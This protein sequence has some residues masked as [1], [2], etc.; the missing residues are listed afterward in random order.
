M[1]AINSTCFR[2]TPFHFVEGTEPSE[3]KRIKKENKRRRK[4][5]HKRDTPSSAAPVGLSCLLAVEFDDLASTLE[6]SRAGRAPSSHKTR[7]V[8]VVAW[9][10]SS[11]SIHFFSF[12]FFVS[13]IDGTSPY[14]QRRQI[15][16]VVT[17]S[18]PRRGEARPSPPITFPQWR[19]KTARNSSAANP[20]KANTYEVNRPGG[21]ENRKTKKE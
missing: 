13:F 2:D 21:C 20:N 12:V 10:S 9:A 6:S 11:V 15:R 7:C 1:Y 19:Q 3:K 17:V 18:R 4:T 8:F 16:D 5:L 14:R